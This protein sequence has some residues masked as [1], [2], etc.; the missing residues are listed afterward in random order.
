LRVLAIIFD[1]GSGCQSDECFYEPHMQVN[2]AG[3]VRCF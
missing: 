3:V 2:D 1:S